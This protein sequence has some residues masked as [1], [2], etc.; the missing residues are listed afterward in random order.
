MHGK[1]ALFWRARQNKTKIIILD[2]HLLL[3]RELS[4]VDSWFGMDSA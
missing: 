2:L 3:K 4:G 1:Y